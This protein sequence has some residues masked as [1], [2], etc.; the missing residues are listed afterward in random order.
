M[1]VPC[2][3]AQIASTARYCRTAEP[4]GMAA[5]YERTVLCATARLAERSLLEDDRTKISKAGCT[6]LAQKEDSSEIA[7]TELDTTS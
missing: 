4:C 2:M 6:L 7:I 1:A 3:K 5:R